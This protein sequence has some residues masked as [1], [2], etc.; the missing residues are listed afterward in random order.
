[1]DLHAG[2]EPIVK[3]GGCVWLQFPNRCADELIE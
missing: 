3:G 2:N 1:M